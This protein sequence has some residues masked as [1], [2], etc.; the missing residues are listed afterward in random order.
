MVF[1]I[2]GAG[3]G[4]PPGSSGADGSA[5]A[6]TAGDA[7]VPTDGVVATPDG[8][9]P[10]PDGAAPDAGVNPSRIALVEVR[11]LTVAGMSTSKVTI[12]RGDS[13]ALLRPGRC[14]FFTEATAGA[15]P[16][17]AMPTFMGLM[18]AVECGPD[19]RDF[20]FSQVRCAPPGD[21]PPALLGSALINGFVL[22]GATTEL[23][24]QLAE[25]GDVTRLMV[26]VNPPTGSTT[27]TAP[28]T[29]P[30]SFF[31]DLTVRWTPLG[32]TRVIVELELGDLAGGPRATVSC[33]AAE[34]GTIT[35]LARMVMPPNAF[36]LSVMQY[37]MAQV[38]D[39]STGQLVVLAERGTAIVLPR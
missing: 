2:A 38:G 7:A 14:A 32:H 29:L 10:G 20:G 34:D 28:T 23:K 6:V 24:V 21:T 15:P 39:P 30:T 18:R 26:G 31:A 13:A 33:H 1:A 3:G 37:A 27:I 16:N 22:P 36:R 35:I 17:I 8:A 12:R 11:D 4:G 9:G 25:M 5:D 19:E